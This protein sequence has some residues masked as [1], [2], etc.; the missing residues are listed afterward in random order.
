MSPEAFPWAIRVLQAPIGLAAAPS[1]VAAVCRAGGLGTLAA[2]WTEPGELHRQLATIRKLT[3]N[4]FAVNLVL[5]FEQRERLSLLLAEGVSAITFSWGVDAELIRL[6]SDAGSIVGVQVGSLDEGMRAAEVG[7]DFLIGQGVEAGGHVQSSRPLIELITDLRGKVEIPVAAA[8]GI[9]DERA[10]AAAFAAGASAIVCGTVFLAAR[11]ADVHPVYR[12]RIFH[13]RGADT[14]LTT[15]FDIG[16]P[17]APHR[18]VRNETVADW[19][20]AGMPMSG[21]RPGEGETVAS[22]DGVSIPRYSDAL[23]TTRTEG[24][25]GEMALYAGVGVEHVTRL[26]GAEQITRRLAGFVE[27]APR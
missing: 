25:V 10:V 8:G 7:A 26:E 6:A 14:T 4:P 18:V 5:A 11:E 17:A 21:E 19:E 2:S 24:D 16:W 1:L 3:R 12:E 27:L 13:A 23:P 20:R 15:L 22:R 9:A